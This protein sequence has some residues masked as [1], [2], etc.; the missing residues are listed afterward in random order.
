MKKKIQ[1]VLTE[2]EQKKITI[3]VKE[4]ENF[5]NT[6]VIENE[7]PLEESHK[8]IFAARAYISFDGEIPEGFT[9]LPLK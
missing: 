7:V 3:I 2:L 1:R 4:V 6:L 5:L 9:E 8:I